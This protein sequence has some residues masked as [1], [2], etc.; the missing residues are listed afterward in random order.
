MNFSLS[1]HSSIKNDG[2]LYFT[3][4]STDGS[5]LNS[6]LLIV[7][8]NDSALGEELQSIVAS[9]LAQTGC[10]TPN[11][12]NDAL[13][14]AIRAS[15]RP[16]RNCDLAFAAFHKKGCLVAQMG[17]S[18]ILQL[19]KDNVEYDSRDQ[20]LDIYSSKAK[21]EQIYDI[22]PGDYLAISATERLNPQ[23]ALTAIFNDEA[24]DDAQRLRAFTA[25][26]DEGKEVEA[27]AL[28]GIE[29][30]TGLNPLANIYDLNVK[31]FLIAFA[32]LAAIIACAFL[33]FNYGFIVAHDQTTVTD[34]TLIDNQESNTT[35]TIVPAVAVNIDTAI[36]P[37]KVDT[38]ISEKQKVHVDTTPVA[39][40]IVPETLE[41]AMIEHKEPQ[42]NHQTH[43]TPVE[44][45]QEPP[46]TGN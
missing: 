21:V 31:W 17:T 19:R 20:V 16:V 24:T 37:A 23:K 44:P 2:E 10:I 43:S 32:L 5:Q 15:S 28:V 35:D 4:S 3:P 27:T 14:K 6:P 36:A 33:T 30:V 40:D 8:C 38:T 22:K 45:I 18:R 12:F 11:E 42:P 46:V 39:P 34:S 9:R 26:A 41:P 7:M 29:G 13:D 1:Y 25:V